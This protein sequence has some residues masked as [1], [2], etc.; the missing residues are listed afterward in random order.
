MP[1]FGN[2]LGRFWHALGFGAFAG[3]VHIDGEGF[4]MVGTAQRPCADGPSFS[5]PSATGPTQLTVTARR[6]DG[7]VDPR[8]GSRGRAQIHTPWR[9][10]NASL[11]AMV[12]IT[13]AGPR[14]IVLVATRDG[15][16]ELQLI[17]VRL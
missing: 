12:S 7:S 15:R 5:A 2:R 16:H 4:T 17:R 10:R 6:P 1:L 8:F 11:E 9:G 3:D 14:A 13:K